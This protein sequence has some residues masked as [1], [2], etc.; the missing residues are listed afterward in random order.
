MNTGI[1][2]LSIELN[3]ASVSSDTYTFDYNIEKAINVAT[4][5]TLSGLVQ[6]SKTL[7]AIPAWYNATEKKLVFGTSTHYFAV[8]GNVLTYA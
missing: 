2:M 1:S 6:S 8:D 7:N 3:R 4:H 5:I